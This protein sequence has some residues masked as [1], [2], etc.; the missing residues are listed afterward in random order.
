MDVVTFT[1]TLPTAAPLEDHVKALE[2]AMTAQH[3]AGNPA[4]A[5]AL[6]S[7]AVLARRGLLAF[8]DDQAKVPFP[9]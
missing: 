9:R 1:I 6:S 7:I 2:D 5:Q 3:I 8:N 4:A